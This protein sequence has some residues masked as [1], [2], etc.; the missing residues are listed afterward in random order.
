MT[1]KD[2]EIIT[3]TARDS[4]LALVNVSKN[5]LGLSQKVGKSRGTH[6]QTLHQINI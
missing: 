5:L 1:A 6:T 4:D 2:H 3:I